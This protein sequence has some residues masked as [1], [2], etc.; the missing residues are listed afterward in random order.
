MR[1]ALCIM[2]LNGDIVA[3][4]IRNFTGYRE[5]PKAGEKLAEVMAVELLRDTLHREGGGKRD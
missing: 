2:D 3:Y 5:D 1:Y 4:R